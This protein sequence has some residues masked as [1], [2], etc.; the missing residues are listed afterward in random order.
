MLPCGGE[1][2]IKKLKPSHKIPDGTN[3]LK[4]SELNSNQSTLLKL[5]DL[6]STNSSKRHPSSCTTPS[7]ETSCCNFLTCMKLTEFMHISKASKE[8]LP[9]KWQCIDQTLS[10]MRKS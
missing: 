10:F 5:H 2:C 7:S 1:Q 3:S 9:R 6:T 8:Q 4:E